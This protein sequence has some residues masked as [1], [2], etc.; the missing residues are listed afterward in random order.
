MVWASPTLKL[1]LSRVDE[2]IERVSRRRSAMP[3]EARDMHVRRRRNLLSLQAAISRQKSRKP[4]WLL[5][6]REASNAA[7]GYA[8]I[9]D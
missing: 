5:V 7:S 4:W 1:F 6:F 9:D 3:M 2:L 8:P